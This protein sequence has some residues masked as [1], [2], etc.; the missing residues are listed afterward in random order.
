MPPR[1]D[2][3]SHSVLSA[4]QFSSESVKLPVVR[5][6]TAMKQQGFSHIDVLKMDIEG[7]E[8]G[9]IEDLVREEIPVAQ[10]LVEFH[11]RF[12]S[13]GTVRTRKSLA[14]LERYGMKIAYVCPR[15]EVFTLVRQG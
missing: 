11:H 14:L 15:K 7:A 8:Y 6:S 10:L 5:L 1:K 4:N 12:S 9:V 2:W 3:I 13:V